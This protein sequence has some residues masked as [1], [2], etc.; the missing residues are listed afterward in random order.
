[1]KCEICDI[2]E[3]FGLDSSAHEIWFCSATKPGTLKQ[4]VRATFEILAVK[5][6]MLHRFACE[7]LVQRLGQLAA[8][9]HS[10]RAYRQHYITLGL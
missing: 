5:A 8:G 1:M 9:I 7:V 4:P 2:I 10:L 3:K 6:A